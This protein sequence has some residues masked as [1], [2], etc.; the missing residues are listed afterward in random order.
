[1]DLEGE[2]V[3]YT[4]RFAHLAETALKVGDRLLYSMRV[5]IM[6]NS[7]S[8]K[9]GIHLHIDCTEG[10]NTFR[11]GL[12][13]I[14]RGR[15]RPNKKQLDYFI[16]VDLFHFRP[17]VTTGY[18][19]EEYKKLFGKEHPAYDVVPEDRH[20]TRDHFAIYWN[21]TRAGTV[22]RLDT[23]DPGYGLCVY[24]CFETEV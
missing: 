6:G 16:D 7:G 17:I 12:A 5:G 10:E 18:L 22:I 1:M 15:P 20:Q 11:Y 9:T 3:K 4:V 21:R 2:I 19:D 24:V 13:D 8:E 14:M 23:A